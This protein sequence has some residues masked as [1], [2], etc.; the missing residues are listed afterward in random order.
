M[1]RTKCFA[2]CLCL[3]GTLMFGSHAN[4]QSYLHD[5]DLGSIRQSNQGAS[6]SSAEAAVGGKA[7]VVTDAHSAS[8]SINRTAKER[9][10]AS[11]GPSAQEVA[12]Q[13][14]AL[15]TRDLEHPRQTQS[16]D[17]ISRPSRPE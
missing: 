4:A 6:P 10:G 12:A 9:N 11:T 7:A 17:R 13:R 14:R 16:F 2:A 15:D 3:A 5:K 1:N 8:E